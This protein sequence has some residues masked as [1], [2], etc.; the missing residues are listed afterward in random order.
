MKRRNIV[1]FTLGGLVLLGLVAGLFTGKIEN[2]LGRPIALQPMANTQGMPQT[3]ARTTMPAATPPGTTP[4]NTNQQNQPNPQNQQKNVLANDTF[5]RQ[6]QTFWGT[7]SD[8]RQWGADAKTKTAFSIKGQQGQI[9]GGQGVLDAVIGQPTDNVDITV[10]GTVNQFGNRV[11]LGILARW[12][13]PKNW[14]KAFIDGNHLVIMKSVK[15]QILTIQQ[16]DLKT[17]A[18]VAQTIR[19]RLVGTMLFAKVWSSGTPEPKNWAIITDDPALSTGQFGIRALEQAT[20][21]ITITSFSA[22]TASIGN[23]M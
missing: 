17:N 5:Q 22:T 23:N 18:G 2:A 8:G 16:V 9:A 1:I 15:G 11:D 6:D 7:A 19:F 21:V 10:S 4:V 20:T 14:Y 3:Q 13:D 12:T